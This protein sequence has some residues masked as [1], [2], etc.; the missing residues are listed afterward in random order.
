MQP[1]NCFIFK[2]IRNIKIQQAL[3]KNKKELDKFWGIKFPLPKV[4]LVNSR[5]DYDLFVGQKTAD[6]MSGRAVSGGHIFIFSPEVYN[7]E[8]CHNKENFW[9]TLKHEQCHFYYYKFMK[10]RQPVWLN[11]GLACYVSKQ[12]KKTDDVEKFLKVVDLKK[13]K[14]WQRMV[15][16]VGFFWVDFLIKY[17]SKERFFKFLKLI[18][19]DTSDKNVKQVFFKVYKI[20]FNKKELK[21]LMAK[22]NII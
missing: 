6:W 13:H 19:K 18:S 2:P 15:Y 10:T 11:E 7:K 8:T 4:F 9:K 14:N 21:R 5:K 16:P 22:F 17:F 20:R 3:I 1:T 12:L